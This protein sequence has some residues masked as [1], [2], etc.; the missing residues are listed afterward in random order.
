[1]INEKFSLTNKGIAVSSGFFDVSKSSQLF[2]SDELLRS[3]PNFQDP[4][5]GIGELYFAGNDCSYGTHS[6]AG[7]YDQYQGVTRGGKDYANIS[8]SH[9]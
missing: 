2:G 8:V 6:P 5:G 4:G 9:L 7:P 3:L 1:M